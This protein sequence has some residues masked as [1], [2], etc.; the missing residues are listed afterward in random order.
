MDVC[1]LTAIGYGIIIFLIVVSTINNYKILFL[2]HINELSNAVSSKVRLFADDCLLYR[3]INNKNDQ[4]TLQKD[5][6]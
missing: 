2:C 3:E 5:K 1:C 4:N 6:T